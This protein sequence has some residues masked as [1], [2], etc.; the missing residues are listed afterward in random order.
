M[1]KILFLIILLCAGIFIFFGGASW[2]NIGMHGDHD[3][4]MNYQIGANHPAVDEQR[5]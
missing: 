2:G 5:R 4:S 3:G 1:S